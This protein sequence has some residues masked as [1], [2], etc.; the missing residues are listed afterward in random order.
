MS[1]ADT[2]PPH[3]LPLDDDYPR[4]IDV[5]VEQALIGACLTDEGIAAEAAS[6]CDPEAFCDPL[7]ERIW[8]T[9][10]TLHQRNQM[11]TPITVGALLSG[12]KGLLEC[13][14]KQYLVSMAKCVPAMPNFR[15]YARIIR[16][17][18]M[19]RFAD[20]ELEA[21]R[22]RL[23]DP[24]KTPLECL[25][26]VVSLAG[27]AAEAEAKNAGHMKLTDALDEVLHE[28]QDKA[29]EPPDAILSG[30]ADLDDNTGGF[31]D[32]DMVVVAGRPGAGKTVLL[33]T[34]ALCAAKAARPVVFFE[35]EMRRRQL[36]HRFICDL[37]YDLERRSKNGAPLPPL[38]YKRMRQRKLWAGED[39][40]IYDAQRLMREWPL[41]IFDSPGMTISD[42]AAHAERFAAKSKVMGVVII[43]YLQIVQATD[44]Y[45]GSK[46]Q[47]VTEISNGIKRLAKRL[48]WPVVI[49]AQLNRDSEK[50]GDKERRPILADLR[51]SGAIEQD[52]DIVIG[53]HRPAAYIERKRPE[54]GNKDPGWTKWIADLEEV[55]HKLDLVIMKNR[56]G[57]TQLIEA[58]VDIGAAAI[59]SQRPAP[60]AFQDDPNAGLELLLV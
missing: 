22:L 51:E 16:D 17:L 18:Q 15:D 1:Y 53:M 57:P 46:V 14:G 9:I 29:N 59:R 47:E 55:R 5:D 2:I 34:I 12:D 50:R 10:R 8:Q 60:P 56:N 3:A 48:G 33:G 39:T 28:F 21:A 52:A 31:Q 7:H 24:G 19:R 45:V 4:Y 44:R 6:L 13:G 27:Y 42:I 23:G 37:D 25:K 40:R 35:L 49:G 38:S 54:K 58:F 11:A 30:I 43:D 41:E 36:L 32:A 20:A 26:D